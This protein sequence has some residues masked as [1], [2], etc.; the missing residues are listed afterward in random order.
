[1][2][3]FKVGDRV[4][5]RRGNEGVV[6]NIKNDPLMGV[7][8]S[9]KF[10]NFKKLVWNSKAEVA[11]YK[12][13]SIKPEFEYSNLNL[14]RDEHQGTPLFKEFNRNKDQG[15]AK[16]KPGLFWTIKIL[17]HKSLDLLPRNLKPQTRKRS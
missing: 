14:F 4:L 6:F 2:K 10:S 7:L 9:V 1:M 16:K 11:F 5:D 15:T 8:Y 17:K 12:E 3:V 13:H